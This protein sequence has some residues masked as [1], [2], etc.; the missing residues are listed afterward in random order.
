[1]RG[2]PWGLEKSSDG[3]EGPSVVRE[4]LGPDRGPSNLSAGPVGHAQTRRPWLPLLSAE[5]VLTRDMPRLICKD[6]ALWGPFRL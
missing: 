3:S 6:G 4:V 2:S 1:M 5:F